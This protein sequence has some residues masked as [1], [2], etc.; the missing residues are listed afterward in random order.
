MNFD[1]LAREERRRLRRNTAIF[2]YSAVGFLLI[3]IGVA[4]VLLI[5]WF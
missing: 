4:F 2:V 5:T 1:E 3:M